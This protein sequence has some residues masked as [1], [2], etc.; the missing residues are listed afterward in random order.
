Q[1]VSRPFPLLFTLFRSRQ[2]K[3]RDAA[4]GITDAVFR[5]GPCQTSH[6]LNDR[7]RDPGAKTA[8]CTELLKQIFKALFGE[9]FQLV[10]QPQDPGKQSG[11]GDFEDRPPHTRGIA[12]LQNAFHKREGPVTHRP[13]LFLLRKHPEDTPPQMSAGYTAPARAYLLRENVPA[14]SPVSLSFQIPD[15]K[16]AGDLVQHFHASA[17]YASL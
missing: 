15:Q 4:G 7:R 2:Q 17:Q 16:Q 14:Q 11:A 9:S 10:Q 3:L 8:S 6:Q 13:V 5:P 12:G 1:N